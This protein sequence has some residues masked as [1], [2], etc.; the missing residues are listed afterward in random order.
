MKFLPAKEM[1]PPIP[2]EPNDLDYVKIPGVIIELSNHFYHF[3]KKKINENDEK[4]SL[5]LILSFRTMQS[6]LKDR[7]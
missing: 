1:P 6:K 5:P 4:E 3:S 2:L 7:T